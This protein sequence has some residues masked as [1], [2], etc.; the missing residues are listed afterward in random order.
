[1]NPVRLAVWL[2]FAAGVSACDPAP[3]TRK[4]KPFGVC[5]VEK[6]TGATSRY[7]TFTPVACDRQGGPPLGEAVGAD[8]GR[9]RFEDVDG[10]GRDEAVVE[11]SA[12]RCR[13]AATPCYDAWRIVLAYDP[14]RR[15]QV[16]VRSRTFLK[17]LTPG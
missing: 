9:L 5:L 6:E 15:P 3:A 13:G 8:H 2:A 10:D 4:W 14:A 17:E 12:D 16:T 1:M 7:R 11:S